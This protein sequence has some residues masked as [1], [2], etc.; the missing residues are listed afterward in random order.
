[1]AYE[2]AVAS[3]VGAEDGGEPAVKAFRLL[4]GTSVSLKVHHVMKGL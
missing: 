2:A 1:L 3:N 4:G